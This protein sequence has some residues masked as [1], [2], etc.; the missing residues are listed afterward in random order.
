MLVTV[1]DIN[2]NVIYSLNVV[3]FHS[4]LI[5]LLFTTKVWSYFFLLSLYNYF[6]YI[7]IRDKSKIG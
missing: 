3:D 4:I 1:F 7:L 5:S 2:N 6:N